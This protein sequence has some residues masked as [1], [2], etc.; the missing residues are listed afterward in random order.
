MM[1]SSAQNTIATIVVKEA[2]VLDQTTAFARKIMKRIPMEHAVY[3]LETLT[4]PAT[5]HNVRLDIQE[6]IVTN[7]FALMDVVTMDTVVVP[8]NALVTITMPPVLTEDA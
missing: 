8:T 5:V 7:L 4:L 1:I 6:T 3:A 2:N